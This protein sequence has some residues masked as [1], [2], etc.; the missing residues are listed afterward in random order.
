MKNM[1]NQVLLG[2]EKI[3][4]QLNIEFNFS[5]ANYNYEKG[6]PLERA[7]KDFF[8]P[9]FPLKYGFSSGYLVDEN[10]NKSRQCDWIIY[11]ALNTSP[12]LSN[13]IDIGT[14]WIPFDGVYGTVEVKR[15][16]SIK[17][18]KSALTQIKSVKDLYRHEAHILN[19]HSIMPLT[20]E[21]LGIPEHVKVP[22]SNHIYSGLFAYSI[23]NDEKSKCYFKPDILL[24][25][26]INNHF[27][28]EYD[29]LPDYII[30]NNDY[31]IFKVELFKND[32]IVNWR[33]N[34]WPIDNNNG[35]AWLKTKEYTSGYFYMNLLSQFSMIKL[36]A[37]YQLDMLVK[38]SRYL[39]EK[40]E[41]NGEL[42]E[43]KK[44]H[45]K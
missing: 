26:L 44:A 24:E 25:K 2:M 31:I 42:F 45:K 5:S 29:K 6:V 41:D 15:S 18:F 19:N 36:T 32:A 14:E 34:V 39:Q 28:I 35:F 20:N 9:Y 23:K 4:N 16:L 11:D 22:K 38:T 10:D 3:S 27:E 43:G 40:V 21:Q 7:L 1:V 30:V 17:Q 12:L 8:R 37:S 33:Y 13:S